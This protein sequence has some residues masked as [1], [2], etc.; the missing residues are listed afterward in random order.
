MKDKTLDHGLPIEFFIGQR[1]ELADR[2][3]KGSGMPPSKGEI[4]DMAR[5]QSTIAA[6]REVKA[7]IASGL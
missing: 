7:E 5:I 4:E 6:L 3:R 1:R 2:W